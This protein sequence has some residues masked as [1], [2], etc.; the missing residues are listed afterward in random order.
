V[1]S[2]SASIDAL[3][4]T[5]YGELRAIAGRMLASERRDHTLQPTALAHEAYLRLQKQAVLGQVAKHDFL[6]IAAI[7]VRRILIEHARKHAAQKRSGR[8]RRIL[9]RDDLAATQNAQVDILALDDAMRRLERFDARKARIV[10]LRFYGGL[11]VDETA[12]MLALSPR[13]IAH[14]WVLARAWLRRELGG[15]RE[16]DPSGNDRGDES[17]L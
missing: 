9:L 16:D 17:R 11:T 12:A 13:S 15:E 10:E 2:E 5:V 4:S 8:R 3:M 7:T 1:S 14:E 6:A